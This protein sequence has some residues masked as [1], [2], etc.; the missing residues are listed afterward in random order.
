MYISRYA[1]WLQDFEIPTKVKTVTRGD[2]SL[3]T[4]EYE[5]FSIDE[6]GFYVYGKNLNRK[7]LI[8][9]FNRNLLTQVELHKIKTR[10][11]L[12]LEEIK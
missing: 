3:V 6:L 9:W 10:A 11:N 1:E 8:K 12:T 5:D 4:P 2:Q 7:D